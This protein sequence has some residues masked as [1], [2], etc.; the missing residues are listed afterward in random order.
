LLGQSLLLAIRSIWLLDN[1][2]AQTNR[3]ITLLSYKAAVDKMPAGVLYSTKSGR[4]VIENRSMDK[5]LEKMGIDLPIN[6]FSL[7][8]LLR[9]QP[10]SL[11]IHDEANAEALLVRLPDEESWMFANHKIRERQKTYFQL[12]AMDVSETDRLNRRIAAANQELQVIGSELT[13]GLEDIERME[14]ERMLLNMKARV[15]DHLGQRLSIMNVYLENRLESLDVG[16]LKNLLLEI[17]E[18]FET[19][20]AIDAQATLAGLIESFALIGVE[21]TVAGCLPKAQCARA[22]VRIAREAATNAVRHSNVRSI[23]ISFSE[24]EEAY[25]MNVS[26]GGRELTG[27]LIEGNGIKGMRRSVAELGGSLDIEPSQNFKV[28]V[29]VPKD[30][31]ESSEGSAVKGGG[32]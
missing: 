26:H 31:L 25:T 15:H 28:L 10:G 17:G 4:P 3:R 12:M 11:A 30:M 5:L 18:I 27:P 22:F 29:H 32:Q 23:A 21:I 24:T 6:T 16:K 13:K 20:P 14:Q 19:S 8:E 1:D 2:L 7:W 9:V